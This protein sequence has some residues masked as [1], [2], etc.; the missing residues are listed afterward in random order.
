MSSPL[1]EFFEAIA[2]ELSAEP[3]RVITRENFRINDE[4]SP[5]LDELKKEMKAASTTEAI[6]KAVEALRLHFKSKDA[7]MPFSYDPTSGRSTATDSEFLSFVKEMGSIRSI[8]RRSKNFECRVAKRLQKR[9]T[10]SIHRVGHPR[11]RKK[12]NAEFN[13]HLQRLGFER[14][15]LFGKEKDGGFD[16]MWLLFRSEVCRTARLY[17]CSARTENSAWTPPMLQWGPEV[18]RS[19]HGGLQANVHV[20]CVLFNDYVHREMLTRKQLNF[21]PLGLTDLA[22][23]AGEATLDIL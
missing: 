16:I 22:P 17:R 12:R 19:Q 6:E 3:S 14:P 15:V 13:K 20:P 23:I 10:G 4:E 11:D 8:G 21:V 7:Q 2:D 9:T 1:F 5:L 18:G